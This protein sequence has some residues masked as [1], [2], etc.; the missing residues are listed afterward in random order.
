M[1][2]VIGNSAYSDAP[3]R[4][5]VNDA[6]DMAAAL[7]GLGFS[8]TLKTDA[9]QRSMEEAIRDFGDSLRSGGV[10]LFYYAGHGIQNRGQNDLIPVR[11]EIQSEADV[12]YRTVDAGYVLAQMEE[13]GTPPDYAGDARQGAP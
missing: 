8:V 7:R 1:A 3:L 11:A 2:L 5:P 9:N 13:G 4:N 6:T 10:G 12:K